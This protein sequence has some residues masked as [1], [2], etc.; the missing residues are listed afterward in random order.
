MIWPR[1]A[2][3]RDPIRVLRAA[4]AD[5][6]WPA[7]DHGPRIDPPTVLPPTRSEAGKTAGDVQPLAA[8]HAD[9]DAERP[10]VEA[11]GGFSAPALAGLLACGN[12]V[13]DESRR[14]P[15]AA[16]GLS[17]WHTPADRLSG[18][19]QQFLRDIACQIVV[20]NWAAQE[21]AQ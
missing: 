15:N 21:P 11:R 16:S 10:A 18:C 8:V 3:R 9:R 5:A 17:C 20:A 1:T 7:P 6:L 12:A 2:T 13:D 4:R 14:A 19:G